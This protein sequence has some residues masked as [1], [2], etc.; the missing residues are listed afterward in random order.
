MRTGQASKSFIVRSASLHKLTDMEKLL[1]VISSFE[2]R[3]RRRHLHVNNA[4]IN[5]GFRQTH[6]RDCCRRRRR[7][8]LEREQARYLIRRPFESRI[9]VACRA[10]STQTEPAAA[11]HVLTAPPQA[12]AMMC[13]ATQ[14]AAE[15][16]VTPAAPVPADKQQSV[17]RICNHTTSTTEKPSVLESIR[18]RFERSVALAFAGP[19]DVT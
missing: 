18:R 1:A 10:V 11:S 14:T 7:R 5:R 2:R 6:W 15:P 4:T 12:V 9:A 19:R 3:Y 16:I 13:V 8:I 17:P